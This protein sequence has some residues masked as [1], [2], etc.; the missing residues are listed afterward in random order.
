VSARPRRE[1]GGG[2]FNDRTNI[3]AVTQISNTAAEKASV[4]SFVL[5]G[6]TTEEVGHALNHE[7]I[8]V[9]MQA[10]R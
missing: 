4:M 3:V 6:Y 1:P 5:D 8:A 10:S 9:R 2:Q 7:G